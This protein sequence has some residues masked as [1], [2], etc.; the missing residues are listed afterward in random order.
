MLRLIAR[1]AAMVALCLVNGLSQAQQH[2]TESPDYARFLRQVAGLQGGR[3]I[4]VNGLD[5]GLTHPFIQQAMGLTNQEVEIL[6]ALAVAYCKKVRTLDEAVRPLIFEARLRSIDLADP[7]ALRIKQLLADIEL[8]R[9]RLVQPVLDELRLQ[10]GET[11]FEAVQAYI[12]SKKD[13]D[14][15]PST[16]KLDPLVFGPKR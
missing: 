6:Q 1:T 5:T 11:R 7:N 15:F 16:G 2:D 9:G 14:F 10:F 13:G 3:P 8:Q 4:L 12:R